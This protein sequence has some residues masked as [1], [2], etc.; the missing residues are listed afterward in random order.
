LKIN[1]CFEEI[2]YENLNYFFLFIHGFLQDVFYYLIK[3][4]SIKINF[5]NESQIFNYI[6][7]GDYEINSLKNYL[8]T[9]FMCEDIGISMFSRIGDEIPI[10]KCYCLLNSK[11]SILNSEKGIINV[12]TFINGISNDLF[13]FLK[14]KKFQLDESL[15][16]IL[17]D[18]IINIKNERNNDFK[19]YFLNTTLID[20]YKFKSVNF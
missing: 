8:K 2:F 3:Q 6:Y 15:V 16:S 20:E 13:I 9:S 7:D 12:Q 11:L 10:I 1:E 19:K 5:P 4:I 18:K 17:D 14:G